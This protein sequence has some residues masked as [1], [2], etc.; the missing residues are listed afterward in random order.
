MGYLREDWLDGQSS[1]P[2][3]LCLDS[4]F[5]IGETLA[6]AAEAVSIRARLNALNGFLSRMEF[7]VL[8][9]LKRRDPRLN[10]DDRPPAIPR[11]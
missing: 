10:G 3:C 6:N 9:Q 8:G 5:G 1:L 7:S 2:R 11:K 4:V